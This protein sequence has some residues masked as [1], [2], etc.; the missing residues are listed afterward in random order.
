MLGG[1]SVSPSAGCLHVSAGKYSDD[2]GAIHE[3]PL[4]EMWHLTATL[5]QIRQ[6]L[7]HTCWGNGPFSSS[8][9]PMASGMADCE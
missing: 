5:E 9:V 7:H 6:H 2:V 3:L 8:V 1:A 4:R